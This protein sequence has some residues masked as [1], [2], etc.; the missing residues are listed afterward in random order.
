VEP[1]DRIIQAAAEMFLEEGIKSVRM[2]DIA[3]RLGVSKRTL[4][5]MF[6]DKRDLLEQSLGYYF[7]RKRSEMLDRT[8]DATNVIEE[9]ILM[10]G[11]MKRDDRD[12]LLATNLKKFY[13]EIFN[14][15]RED[16]HRFSFEKFNGLLDRGMREQLFLPDM[17]KELALCTLTHT[18]EALFEKK[19][20]FE[21]AHN[22]SPQLAFE[23]VLINFFRGL[24]THKGIE[25]I[26]ELVMNYRQRKS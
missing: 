22:I 9:I 21:T 3:T 10:M 24:A 5:E 19:R 26:D 4:Y 11:A 18:M 14:H 20:H 17:N 16:M 1:K 15:L 13:P 6:G 25:I 23:Y 12:E 8:A 7:G 2:D